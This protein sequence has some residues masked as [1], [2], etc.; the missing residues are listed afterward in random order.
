[1]TVTPDDPERTAP[2]VKLMATFQHCRYNNIVL[3][4]MCD[5]LWRRTNS[6]VWL[7]I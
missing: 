1:M 7:D 6:N 4:A 5:C 3:N 2:L